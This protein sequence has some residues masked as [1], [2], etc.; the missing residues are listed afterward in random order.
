MKIAFA[1][2]LHFEFDRSR[3]LSVI[4]NL[5]PETD[6]LVLAG[7]IQVADRIIPDLEY[8]HNALPNLHIVYVTG[9]HEFYGEK[10]A[11]VESAL[12][13]AFEAHPKIH[14]LEKEAFELNGVVF[15][16]TTL[17][18]GFDAYPYFEQSLSEENAIYGISD[19][20]II[21]HG[22][23]S[24][25]PYY[26]KQL[27]HENCEWLSKSLNEF[28]D[29]TTIVVTHFPPSP[30]LFHGTIPVNS[31][32]NYFQADCR[33]IINQYEPDYWIYGHNHWSDEQTIGKTMCVS[34]QLGYPAEHCKTE[35]LFKYIL[36]DG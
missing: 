11:D 15:L 10:I 3:I 9:N 4:E 32:S 7:D 1:S 28:K 25:L 21:K 30:S 2:D 19:F 27:H 22:L 33:D 34:N 6:V 23:G 13:N 17:W 20:R 18:T 36:I 14:Y 35:A 31:M 12:M 8:L 24:F 26:C 5:E 16:G 29:N